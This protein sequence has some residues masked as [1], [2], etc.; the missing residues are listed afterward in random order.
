VAEQDSEET[1]DDSY[2]YPNPELEPETG[3]LWDYVG[4]LLRRRRAV[5]A[6]FFLIFGFLTIRS[7]LTHPVYRG[8][9]RVLIER[10]KMSVVN[11]KQVSEIDDERDD[12][13]KTQYELLQSRALAARTILALNLL[14]APAFGG[15]HTSQEIEAAKAAAP[16]SSEILES[17]VDVFLRHLEIEP[18][19]KS[20][21]VAVSFEADTPELAAAAANRQAQ[22]YIE[23]ALEFRYQT[24][25]EAGKWLDAQVA[26]QRKKVEEADQALQRL[27]EQEGLVNIEER[28]DLIAQR[29]KELGTKL[30]DCKSTRLER[31]ALANQMRR[32]TNPEELPEVMR[33]PVVQSL[34][35]E[36]ATL[37]R[38]ETTLLQKYLDQ[39]PEVIRVR[40]QIAQTHHKLAVESQAIIREAE[41]AYHAALAQEQSVASAIE[42]AKAEALDLER[43]SVAYDSVKREV[44]AQKQVLNGLL[45][46]SKETDVATEL[47]S[48]NIRIV[49]A[50]ATPRDPV[51]P[52]R[53]RDA[54]LGIVLGLVGGIG[55][56]FFLEYLD[57]TIK[58]PHDVRLHLGVPLLAVI[59]E[60]KA[61][62]LDLVLT[63]PNADARFSDNYRALRT[64]LRYCWSERK[65]R[66]VLVTSSFP[67]EGKTLTAVNLSLALAANNQKVLLLDADMRRPHC[68][69]LLRRA[70][71]PGLS[72]ILVGQCKAS[73]AIQ[74]DVSGGFSFLASGTSVPSPT[75][76]IATPI[77]D[78]VLEGI[79]DCYQWVVIDTPPVGAVS[80]ALLLASH[81]DG[82][83]VVA[84][85]EMVAR[86]AV[87]LT[88]ERLAATRA[89]VLGVA[90]NR[91][92]IEKY[93]Y[94]YGGRYHG[95]YHGYHD[96]YYGHVD[97]V[98]EHGERTAPATVR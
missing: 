21:I 10:E 13:Y 7:L 94:Y 80:E 77:L 53:L 17:A 68:H 43:R 3:H 16:G 51:R 61:T 83:V 89:R 55:L 49:D 79:R 85:A 90:L 63:S 93:S 73:E 47:K 42:A 9:A 1:L 96:A 22:L 91:A 48:S 74:A 92:K 56:A 23:Q 57:N 81:T 2:P 28:R 46:R 32:A 30:N 29:L 14:N 71:K 26:E 25:A 8:T 34:R 69:T 95:A 18:V 40:S 84:G 38:E 41:N 6:V 5:L 62:D 4:V 98:H 82:V 27:K 37:E 60:S 12:Y 86:N 45:S 75:D 36:L 70:N 31:E 19:S 72:D 65:P 54:A 44:E 39:H 78:A 59:P 97:A 88:L 24:S 52:R 50:A 20:R 15:P 87:R 58:T 67:G 76:L 66:V 11:F 33:S 64:S 35:M